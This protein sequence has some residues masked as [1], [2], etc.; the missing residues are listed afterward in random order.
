MDTIVWYP[1]FKLGGPGRRKTD[2]ISRTIGYYAAGEYK[3]D[4]VVNRIM[5]AKREW[6]F[7]VVGP[8]YAL[9]CGEE[10]P[11][12]TVW[13]HTADLKGFYDTIDL[14]IAPSLM[15]E[16]FSRVVLEACAYGI[17]VIANRVGGIPEA[18]GGGGI[19]IDV[20]LRKKFDLDAIANRYIDE[21]E[22]LFSNPEYYRVMSEKAALRAEE[23]ETE[24]RI[25]SDTNYRKYMA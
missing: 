17:P 10:A 9:R 12:L 3:G 14:M 24:Q 5:K 19:L 13:G 15:E 6:Q 11:N 1:L 16:G 4:A 25:L 7:V 23:Y 21:I 20:D 18:M 2:H 22:R 8:R